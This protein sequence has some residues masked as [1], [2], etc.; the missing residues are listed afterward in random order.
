[1]KSFSPTAPDAAVLGFLR[2]RAEAAYDI[3]NTH[4]AIQP[5]MAGD[6]LTIADFSLSGYV[7]YPPEERGFD[8]AAKYRYIDAWRQRLM[9]LPGWAD[10]YDL[11]PGE[12]IAPRW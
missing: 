2:A 12:R 5:F 10:P 11:L 3:V 7:F 9:A 1:M 8:I 4:L 6:A